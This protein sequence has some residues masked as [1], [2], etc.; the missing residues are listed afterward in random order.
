MRRSQLGTVELQHGWT[1]TLERMTRR[2]TLVVLAALVSFA[3]L[4]GFVNLVDRA[5]D[6]TDLKADRSIVV[7]AAPGLRWADVT[8]AAYPDLRETLDYGAIGSVT[9]RGGKTG[10]CS[11]DAW[12]SLSAGRG[13]SVPALCTD[14]PKPAVAGS[15]ARFADRSSW[16]TDEADRIGLLADRYRAAGKCVAAVGQ[17]AALGALGSDGTV[18]S[19]T[20]SAK[21]AR[22]DKCALTLVD[23]SGGSART[24]MAQLNEAFAGIPASATVIVTGLSDGPGRQEPGD[25]RLRML[26]VLGNSVK[27]GTLWSASVRQ[28]GIVQLPDL[29]ATFLAPLGPVPSQVQGSPLQLAPNETPSSSLVNQAR[30]TD[31]QLRGVFDLSVP[32]FAGWALLGLTLGILLWRSRTRVVGWLPPVLTVWAAVPA[33]T[34]LSALSPWA[35]WPAAPVWLVVFTLLFAGIIAAIA[36][37]G[38]WRRTPTGPIIAVAI[39]TWVVIGADVM[40]GSRLQFGS[41]LGLQPINGGRFYGM[42]NVGFGLFATSALIAAGLGAGALIVRG[43]RRLAAVTIALAGLATV[44]IDGWPGWGAD[45]GGPPAVVLAAVVLALLAL[46][47]RL[48][49]RL[50][51]FAGVAALAVA[52]VL[53]FADWLRPAE[54]RTHLGK[55]VQQVIDGEGLGVVGDK[56]GAN[57][58]LVFG[59]PFSPLVPIALAVLIWMIARPTSRPG[60]A[61]D[62]ALARVRFG[63]ETLIGLLV[64]WTF[65]FVLNDS[66][67]A[68]L[69]N[70]IG[71]ALA[72]ALALAAQTLRREQDPTIH[73]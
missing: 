63:R 3:A 1:P 41:L 53:A 58:Q 72:F 20:P 17:D 35:A 8:R 50:V 49:L 66:G 60:R 28:S 21:G 12:L 27:H 40:H 16:N 36:Y 43:E 70:G 5:P 29:T 22:Y 48:R 30:Q 19:F 24:T 42:G 33:A 61:L 39:A 64:L 10:T 65:G 18:D 15:G 73:I 34:F 14:P 62:D 57:V 51:L 11:T 32:F 68:L 13:V 37:A 54:S 31:D 71:L 25:A 56:L 46:A 23:A 69:L 4:L 67:L 38:R 45:F 9:P 7:I 44:I 2:Y 26:F 52:A 55:F 47:V 6:R 59:T